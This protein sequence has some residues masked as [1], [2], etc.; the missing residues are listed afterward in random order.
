MPIKKEQP[1]ITNIVLIGMPGTYKSSAGHLLAD[2][3]GMNF[4][5][6]DDFFEFEYNMKI[7]DCFKEYGE[8]FFRDLESKIIDRS[9]GFENA[10]IATG[11]GVPERDDNM[12]KLKR[13]GLIILLTCD[14]KV[15]AKRVAKDNTRPL[16]RGGGKK[17]AVKKLWETRREKY[18]KYADITVD[19]TLLN[20]WQTAEAIQKK[21]LEFYA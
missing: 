11:G 10:V 5:D 17:Q 12:E 13:H 16:L 20:P 19:N 14:V 9:G 8:E 3:L 15:I 2:S 1:L 21:I 18:K 4:L 6:T 7:A